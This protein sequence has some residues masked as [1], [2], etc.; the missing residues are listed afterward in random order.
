MDFSNPN[1]APYPCGIRALL[2]CVPA[3]TDTGARLRLYEK[4]KEY[5]ERTS[6]GD[7]HGIFNQIC[8][9]IV[10][11]GGP[12]K[13][14][15]RRLMERWGRIRKRNEDSLDQFILRWRSLME[16]MN[17]HGLLE[18]KVGGET[19]CEKAPF[20]SELTL[21]FLSCINPDCTKQIE[22]LIAEEETDF[23]TCWDFFIRW[24][25]AEEARNHTLAGRR[26]KD[27]TWSRNRAHQIDGASKLDVPLPSTKGNGPSGAC[28]YCEGIGCCTSHLCIGKEA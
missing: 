27:G 16:E 24:E 10:A 21:K 8:A 26:D 25:R 28:L 11:G 13:D 3:D 18:T 22:V 19:C 2:M 23:Q 6:A 4:G 15:R 17:S 12:P 20:D 9:L 14:R 7:W 5:L 1:N